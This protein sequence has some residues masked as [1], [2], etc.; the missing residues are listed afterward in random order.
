MAAHRDPMIVGCYA[1]TK[2]TFLEGREEV[3]KTIISLNNR[4][5]L[6]NISMRL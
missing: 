3:S 4:I 1:L 6:Y 2:N 5:R